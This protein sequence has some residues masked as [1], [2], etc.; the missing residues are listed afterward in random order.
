MKAALIS[1]ARAGVIALHGLFSLLPVPK[2]IVYLSRQQDGTTTD[3]DMLSS[4]IAEHYPGWQNVILAK[5]L[6]NPVRYAPHVFRQIYHIATCRA[7]VLDS[8]CIVVS[9]LGPRV[10]A[11]VLQMWHALGNM[12]KFGYMTLDTPEGRSSSTARL[13]HMHEG[14][15]S[16]L[17]SSASFAEDLAAGF[18][19]DASLLY[20]APLPRTDL[21]VDEAVRTR[22]RERIYAAF[23]E[24]KEKR[25][26]VYC[27]TF[28][29]EPAPNEAQAMEALVNA[30]DFER[31]N[32]IFKRHPV[33]TQRIEDARVLQDYD[34]DAYNMLYIADYA[35]SDYSTVIYE[36]GLLGI[37]LY[38]Y[39][40][41]WDSYAGKRALNIDMQHDVPAL[42]SADANEIMAAVQAGEFDAESY[43]EF[44]KDNVAVPQD[45]SCTQRVAEHLFAMIAAGKPRI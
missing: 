43:A 1:I 18:N 32:L 37:P 17:V 6:N 27:P 36:A 5:T 39:A 8:Y 3:F 19:M 44:T 29:R 12:K 23:P 9:L 38:L 21:L 20:E 40:Y 28:R 35:I 7:V 13:L 45:M 24:L 16:A 41:D 22:E 33:S 2:R 31:Y 26:I 10:K 15:D 11:P 14:Y 30:V 42:F 34:Q 25:N 4:Y